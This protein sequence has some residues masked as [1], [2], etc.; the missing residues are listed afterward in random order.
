VCGEYRTYTVDVSVTDT[1]LAFADD[2]CGTIQ[3][4]DEL[5]A[6]AWLY[7]YVGADD[8]SGTAEWQGLSVWGVPAW[9]L[10]ASRAPTPS[11]S[12]QPAP[13]PAPEPTPH[14]TA[15]WGAPAVSDAFE[16]F[17]P[18][19]WA[20]QC[21]GCAYEGGSLRVSGDSMLMRSVGTFGALRHIAGSLIKNSQCNDHAVALSSDAALGWS[22]STG[23]SAARFLW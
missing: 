19:L 9:D 17:E 4:D 1:T 3:L 7:V 21:A 10:T 5:G 22:W 20:A 18:R 23:A 16:Q 13:L 2:Y 8:D 11:P 6:A 14:P 12:P 15:A